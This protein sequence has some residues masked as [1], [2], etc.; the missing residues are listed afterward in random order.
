MITVEGPN[1]DEVQVRIRM[2]GAVV[3]VEAVGSAGS[4]IQVPGG[5]L[6]PLSS[7]PQPLTEGTR[8]QVGSRT[9]VFRANPG[10]SL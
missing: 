9:M 2:G 4:W 6:A 10:S 7:S 5:Q 3:T 1:V 8:L